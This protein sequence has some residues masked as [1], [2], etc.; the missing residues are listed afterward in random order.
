MASCQK[1]SLPLCYHTFHIPAKI[2]GASALNGHLAK[3]YG[4]NLPACSPSVT[5]LA[6]IAVSFAASAAAILATLVALSSISNSSS[7]E[8]RQRADT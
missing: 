3:P 4:T 7:G 2:V 8:R 6:L 5:E 1:L